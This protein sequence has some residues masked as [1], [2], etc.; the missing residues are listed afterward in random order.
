MAVRASEGAWLGQGARDS[1]APVAHRHPVVH[2]GVCGSLHQATGGWQTT[3]EAVARRV[4]EGEQEDAVEDEEVVREED[5]SERRGGGLCRSGEVGGASPRERTQKQAKTDHQSRGS[6]RPVTGSKSRPISGSQ[7]I[8][9]TTR[10]SQGI[11]AESIS[12]SSP[13]PSFWC[14]EV[15]ERSIMRCGT[16]RLKSREIG[17]LTIRLCLQRVECAGT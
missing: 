7:P 12:L 2:E 4:V 8:F 3:A 10:L 17:L 16:T 9:T 13:R 1:S 15:H 5:L 6:T 14:I 11:S